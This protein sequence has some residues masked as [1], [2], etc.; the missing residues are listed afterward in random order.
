[1]TNRRVVVTGL[2]AVSPLAHGVEESWQKVKDGISGVEVVTQYDVD[3][4]ELNIVGE[5][6]SFDAVS[7]FGARDARR[8]DRVQQFALYAATQAM[9]DSGLKI[10]DS[11]CYDIGCVMGTGIGSLASI[12]SAHRG[13]L[14]RG[15]RGVS[16]LAI[17]Q[18]LS[19][20]VSARISISFG[21][22]GPNYNITSACATG[23][24]CIGDAA[25]LIRLGR[26]K[27]VLTGG[28]EAAI[29]EMAMSGFH[30]MK[31]T[32][33]WEGDPTQASRPFDAHRTGFVP[34][35]GAAVLLI[36]ELDHALARGATIYAEITG[37]GHTSDAYHI[38][39]PREDAQ[40]ATIAMKR[41]LL[42]ANLQPG[43]LCYLNAHGT[44]TV[45]NDVSE[46]R[47]IKQALG[48]HA[49]VLPISSTKSMTGH[50]LG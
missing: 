14:E 36:E 18:I 37:Y 31:A 6:K 45:L 38:T 39:A 49:Y 28:S 35:E 42:D 44:G 41:A 21:L 9:E 50:M 29:L 20:S 43:D 5:V 2:G 23:N 7:L 46:T 16:P 4:I 47:A 40:G 10:T 1:M 48:E 12:Q 30:N 22:C 32:T 13:Y 27:A 19:D 8:M 17:P 33:R 24:N 26:A 25:D 15:Q 3:V 11:N 34:A